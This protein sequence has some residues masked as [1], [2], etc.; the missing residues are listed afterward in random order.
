[1]PE[2]KPYVAYNDDLSEFA[3]FDWE[4]GALKYAVKHRWNVRPLKFDVPLRTQLASTVVGPTEAADDDVVDAEI[5]YSEAYTE[6]AEMR[7]A[8][9]K[10]HAP[11]HTA[12]T[13]AWECGRHSDPEHDGFYRLPPV[14]GDCVDGDE[15]A[16]EWPCPTAQALGVTA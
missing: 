12:E 8:V 10:I 3:I 15:N 9:L 2:R 6:L 4:I 7:L 5:D 13:K 11:C 14:C 16:V 1:V